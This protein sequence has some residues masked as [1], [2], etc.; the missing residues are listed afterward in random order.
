MNKV[1]SS[2]ELGTSAKCV[3]LLENIVYEDKD[4][5]KTGAFYM[6]VITIYLVNKILDRSENCECREDLKVSATILYLLLDELI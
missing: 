5:H 6:R 4:I 2:R 3:A 1:A